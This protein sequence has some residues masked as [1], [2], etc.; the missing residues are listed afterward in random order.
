MITKWFLIG[1][2]LPPQLGVIEQF[3]ASTNKALMVTDRGDKYWVREHD[4]A[5]SLTPLY[6]RYLAQKGKRNAKTRK[7]DKE[8]RT[9]FGEVQTI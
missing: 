9:K 8:T 6:I 1:Y 2:A 5:D 3:D 7:A 4:L